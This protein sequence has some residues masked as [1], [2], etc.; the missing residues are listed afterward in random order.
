MLADSAYAAKRGGSRHHAAPSAPPA[1][2]AQAVDAAQLSAPSGKG[3]ARA[4]RRRDHK[5]GNSA[6]SRRLLAGP[7][8]RQDR[9]ELSKGGPRVSR[10]K[11][12]QAERQPRPPNL[13]AADRDLER[14]GARRLRDP[15]GGREGPVQ[16]D[17]PEIVG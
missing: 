15:A 6:R 14:P 17:D 3:R 16:S 5:V 12:N 2:D 1:L 9:D 10:R 8:R 11:R 4:R 13:G 7:D